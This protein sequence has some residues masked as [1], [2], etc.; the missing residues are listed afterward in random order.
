MKLAYGILSLLAFGLSF[1]NG[2]NAG[3]FQLK[4][5]NNWLT[6][7]STKD[8]DV[9]IGIARSLNNNAQVVSSQSGFYAVIMGPYAATSI[10]TV[11]KLDSTIY[12]LPKDAL[13]SNGARYVESVWKSPSQ[14]TIMSSYDIEKPLQLSAGDVSATF[15]LDKVGDDLFSTVVTG[16]EKNGPNFTFTV[17]KKGEFVPSSSQAAFIKLDAK[18]TVPQLVFTRFSGGAHCCT[19]TWIAAKPDGAAGWSLTEGAYLDGGGYW[20]EDVDGDGGQEL[21]SVDNRFLYA[22]DS[23]AGSFAPVHI[24]KF[25]DGKIEDV[26][27]E[28]AMQARLKQDLAGIEYAAKVDPGM[29]KQN[30]FLAGWAASKMRLGQG[31]DAWQ[32]VSENMASDT[33][34]GPQECTSGQS[35]DD[36]PVDNLKPIPV[37]KGLADFLKEN[38]YGPLPD[39]AEALLH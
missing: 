22:F 5:K 30:G 37:L 26:T 8:L 19:M 25:R 9:A 38:G 16:E 36:C 7:A 31:M 23:Y 14:S 2:A 39:A 1:S 13:L 24:S 4:G 32:V 15:T 3:S 10:T 6:V 18:S 27:E 35:L 33:G 28:P 17:D 11:K 21:L 12:E 20:F 29:W 34:F